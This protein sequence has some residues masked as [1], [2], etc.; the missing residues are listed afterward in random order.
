M[1]EMIL[2]FLA[3]HTFSSELMSNFVSHRR[4][5]GCGKKMHP[6]SWDDLSLKT[7]NQIEKAGGFPGRNF[8]MWMCSDKCQGEKPVSFIWI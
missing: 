1:W 7:Q 3:R 2:R 8:P 4:C 5:G 6:V